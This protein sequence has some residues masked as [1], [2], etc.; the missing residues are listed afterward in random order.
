MFTTRNRWAGFVM[1]GSVLAL[2]FFLIQSGQETQPQVTAAP[3]AQVG[4][5]K[6]RDAD[7]NA[8]RE[9]MQSFIKA[10][11]AGN[12][13]SVAMHW[14]EEGEYQ[15]EDGSVFRGR[16]QL[17]EA[18]AGLFEKSKKLKVSVDMESLRFI[19]EHTAIEEGYMKVT[20]GDET[21]PTESKYTVLH[22]RENGKWLMSVV[23]DWP[24]DGYSLRDL[25]WLIGDWSAERDGVTVTTSYKWNAKKTFIEARFKIISKER[26]VTAK[27]MIGKDPATGLLRSWTFEEDGGFGVAEWARDGKKWVIDAA[28]VTSDG[29]TTSSTNILTRL[30]SDSFTWHATNR[31]LDGIELED[32][33]PIRVSRV[34]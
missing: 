10:F 26:T 15:A 32:I 34:K 25:Q 11:E 2:A 27:K 18:Y 29:T 7:R 12:A 14:T 31:T 24:R 4:E 1:V 13:K 8:I 23:R 28:G 9:K 21:V 19:G 17:L 20:K 5:K 33:A 3:P 16:K 30:D 22:V 6:N